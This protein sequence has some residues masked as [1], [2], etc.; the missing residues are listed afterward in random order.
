MSWTGLVGYI[1][2]SS[3]LDSDSHSESITDDSTDSFSST[4]KEVHLKNYFVKKVTIQYKKVYFL[5]FWTY[6]K[7]FNFYI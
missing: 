2:K 4:H 1:N 5:F 7:K 6:F 3:R